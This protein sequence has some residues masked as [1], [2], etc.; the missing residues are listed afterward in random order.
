MRHLKPSSM[1]VSLV[2]ILPLFWIGVTC[3]R[4]YIPGY[5]IQVSSSVTVQEGLCVTIPCTFTAN[6]R[7]TFSNSFGYWKRVSNIDY[8]VATNDK[9]SDVIQTNFYLTG[10]PDTGDCSL[11]IADARK[12]DEGTY[13]FRFVESKDSPVIYGYH[14]D[15]KT[16]IIVDPAYVT[17]TSEIKGKKKN[18]QDSIKVNEGSSV[19]LRCSVPSKLTL[20]VTWTDGKNK[21][22]KHGTGEELELRLENMKMNHTG[23]YTCS[24]FTVDVIYSRNVNVSVQ[25]PPRNME[26]TIQSSKGGELP[27]SPQVVIDQTETLTLVCRADGDP[28]VSVVWVKGDVDTEANKT[29]N[30]GSSAMIKVTSPMADVYQCVAW[31]GV[32]FRE[33]RIQVGTKQDKIKYYMTRTMDSIIIIGMVLGNIAALIL[34][35]VGSYFFLKR[36]MEKRFGKSSPE[37]ETHE[38]ESTYQ[39]LKGQKIDI[40]DNLK[41]QQ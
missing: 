19:I 15:I 23:T 31:N 37:P 34:I 16:N 13:F 14:R 33:R 24:A 12:E 11:T 26:I 28:P 36:R 27:A 2:V 10:N 21:V 6:G 38:T 25:Y 9:S 18:N 22:L 29:S 7:K 8:T 1:W 4:M 39:E 3:Q 20:N 5:S 40:Y 17:I 35:I 32:G 30:S 41:A